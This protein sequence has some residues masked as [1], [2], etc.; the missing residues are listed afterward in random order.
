[1]PLEE[2]QLNGRI[3]SLITA[4]TAGLNWTVREELW[5]AL[6]GPRTKPDILITRPDAPPIVLENEYHPAS[7]VYDDCLRCLGRELNPETTGAAGLVST[8]IAIRSPLALRDC[9]TGDEARQLLADHAVNLEYAVYQSAESGQIRFPRAGYLSGSIR[10]LVEFIRPA[11]EPRDAIAA[12]AQSLEEGTEVAAQLILL[13]ARGD[14]V[15]VGPRIGEQL[16]QPWPSPMPK[17]PQ[18]NHERQQAQADQTA[19][20]QTAKMC[21]AIIINALAYQQNLAGYQGIRDLEDIRSTTVGGRLTKMAVLDEWNN[22]LNV[23][24]WPIFH[25][26]KELLLK[27]PSPAVTGMLPGMVNTANSMQW[28]IQQNDVAGTVFQ[29][30]IADRQTLATYYTRPE[31]TTLAAHLAIPENLD[32]SDPNTV[33]N[34]HIADYACGTGGL[35]L[36]A[37][38]R[39][40]ELH[41]NNGGEPDSI[42]AYMMENALTGCDI[43]PAAVHLTSSL[44]SSVAPRQ[45]YNGT[46]C[47]LY[48]FGGIKQTD[49]RGV[50]LRNADGSPALETDEKEIPVVNLGSLELLNLNTTMRQVVLPLNEQMALG[51]NGQRK[52]IEVEMT[53]LSQSLVI[54]NPPFTTPTNHSADH[55]DTKNPAFAAFGTTNDEQDAMEV[56]TRSLSRGT[57]GDGYAGLGSQFAAI[58]NNMVKPGG[59]ITLILPIS[60]MVGGSYDGKT[61]RS[62]QKLRRL[63]AEHYNDI[64]VVTIAKPTT[65]ESA[66][67]ADTNLAE[68]IIVARSLH[69]G[70]YPNYQA[71]FVN[72][73][74]RPNTKLEAQETARAI[75]RSI[76]ATV[77]LGTDVP[78]RIGES[79][80]GFVSLESVHPLQK[81]T[82]TRIANV[83]LARRARQLAGGELHLP[84]RIEPI[85]VPITRIGQVGSVGPVHRSILAAFNKRDGADSGTEYPM[86]WNHDKRGQHIQVQMLTPPDS[87]GVIKRGK[88]A[89]AA[90]LWAQASHLH[91]NQEFQ[92]NANPTAAVLTERRSAGGSTWPSLQMETVEM[93]KATCVWLNGTLGIISYW[94]ESNRMQNGRGRTTV[95]AI[96]N[97][98]TLDVANLA[99]DRLQAAVQIYDDLCRQQMLPANEAWHDP[100]RQEL[101]RRILTEVLGLDTAAVEQLAIL[102]NQWCAE[103]T[104]TSTKGTGPAR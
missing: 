53:P 32:W 37:Y 102:R 23:N 72:L 63:L 66:F 19:R 62:W 14:G 35:V 33:R 90:K 92:F 8:V 27:I 84:Q 94:L 43:M 12:A 57:I 5:D 77:A 99:D 17:P 97:I 104:V 38:Q 41:R 68:A 60:S 70:E 54:M 36:A 76:T 15:N 25:I 7:T 52:A 93:E 71:H 58:A 22:I 95:T 26:A 96:P 98:P 13:A 18:T 101:D 87:A 47:I 46:R 11:A 10:N 69:S 28:A 48:P 40:R 82:M 89:D 42:H 20:E 29:R 31:S 49:Q 6:R 2:P 21:A 44:L 51:S 50:V 88:E 56:K 4:M 81:W 59:H 78:I 73:K 1:M 61:I 67:S 45:T 16:R 91:I 103:P 75:L 3:A 24:Y 86:L 74:E 30:L 80:V 55:V 65:W 9:A 85:A 100:V 64:V 34:Y 79:E 83:S 39:V